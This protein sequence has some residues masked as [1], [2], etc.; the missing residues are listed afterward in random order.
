MFSIIL[1]YQL[2]ITVKWL[3]QT[4][5]CFSLRFTKDSSKDVRGD[6][7]FFMKSLLFIDSFNLCVSDSGVVVSE[8][9]QSVRRSS[10]YSY[11]K[12]N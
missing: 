8:N 7:L 2:S 5:I 4:V 10:K 11:K 3:S 9:G 6:L 12:R 1:Q